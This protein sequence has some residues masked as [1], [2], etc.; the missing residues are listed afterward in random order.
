MI[1]PWI[2]TKQLMKEAITKGELRAF[3]V[4]LAVESPRSSKF[5][6][7]QKIHKPGNLVRP[8]VSACNCP[9]GLIAAYFAGSPLSWSRCA[10]AFPRPL[11]EADMGLSLRPYTL[12]GNRHSFLSE[13]HVISPCPLYPSNVVR[14]AQER[15][16]AITRDAII[17]ERA[18]VPDAQP[19]IPLVLAY[20]PTKAVVKNIM[21]KNFHLLRDDAD[22]GDILPTSTSFMCSSS[23]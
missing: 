20:Y 4:N 6:I 12:Q 18:D 21:A 1:S 7:L 22:T 17:S 13:L 2:T 10:A 19:T 11:F 5:F 16:S 14:R 9:T 15:V 3:T 8:I 23:R